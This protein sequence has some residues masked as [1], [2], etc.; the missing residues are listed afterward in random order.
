M[1]PSW[2]EGEGWLAVAVAAMFFLLAGGALLWLRG[3]GSRPHDPPVAH[4]N[5]R[6]FAIGCVLFGSLWL[7]RAVAG[8]GGFLVVCGILFALSLV[9]AARGRLR[10]S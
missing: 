6:W 4:E 5:V 9:F 8:I 7:V 2:F 1:D 10:R 3:P